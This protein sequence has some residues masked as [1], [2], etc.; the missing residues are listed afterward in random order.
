LQFALQFCKP[1]LQANVPRLFFSDPFH[2]LELRI[3]GC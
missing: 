3:L 1:L 2:H